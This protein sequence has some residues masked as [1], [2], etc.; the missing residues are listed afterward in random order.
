M[1]RALRLLELV[2]GP[3]HSQRTIVVTFKAGRKLSNQ[4]SKYFPEYPQLISVF[5]PLLSRVSFQKGYVGILSIST[6]ESDLI[7]GLHL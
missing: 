6:S 1:S 3:C 4:E 7:W 5:I 2:Q